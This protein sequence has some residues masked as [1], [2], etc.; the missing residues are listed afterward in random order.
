MLKI[1]LKRTFCGAGHVQTDTA[2]AL[3][4]TFTDNPAA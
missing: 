3:P 4:Q 2:F 1:R